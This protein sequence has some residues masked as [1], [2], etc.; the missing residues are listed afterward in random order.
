[1]LLFHAVG[2]WHKYIGHG[3]YTFAI[4]DP[5]AMAVIA[6]LVALLGFVHEHDLERTTFKH[7]VGFGHHYIVLGLLYLNMSLWI[8]SLYPGTVGWV[9]IFG[10]ASVA[11]IVLGARLKD[12]RASGF[13]VVFLSINMYTRFFETFWDKL[14]A[15]LIFLASGVAAFAFGYL[16]EK[17]L[18]TSSKEA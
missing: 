8:L 4:Q 1:L 14:S 11:Q 13:G 16:F 18:R 2:S 6:T 12:G 10:I 5:R 15:G 3:T 9:A 17:Q 7:H